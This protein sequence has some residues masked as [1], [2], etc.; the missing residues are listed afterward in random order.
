MDFHTLPRREL[1]TLC[2]WNKIP[3]NM[4]NLAMADALQALPTVEGLEDLIQEP[5][6]SLSPKKAAG[7]PEAPSRSCRRTSTRKQP[8]PPGSSVTRTRRAMAGM[9]GKNE[10]AAEKEDGGEDDVVVSGVGIPNSP[11]TLSSRGRKTRTL[12]TAGSVET[13]E[14]VEAVKKVEPLPL[15][16]SKTPATRA[17][18]GRRAA[19]Q[20]AKQ[21]AEEVA[22]KQEEEGAPAG[23]Q[24]PGP[25]TARRAS[26]RRGGASA[27]QAPEE[28]S[29][30]RST[31]YRTRRAVVKE[32]AETGTAAR[33]R[34]TAASR[35]NCRKAMDDGVLPA[36]VSSAG[37]DG[38]G[39]EAPA[40]EGVV[41]ELIPV[42]VAGGGGAETEQAALSAEPT[43]E[44]SLPI[45]EVD[46]SDGV[47]VD[48]TV[49]KAPTDAP[50]V[51]LVGSEGVHQ[52]AAEETLSDDPTVVDEDD[53]TGGSIDQTMNKPEEPADQTVE[54]EESRDSTVGDAPSDDRGVVEGSGSF[55][56]TAVEELLLHIAEISLDPTVDEE[57]IAIAACSNDQTA[58]A[59]RDLVEHLLKEGMLVEM[60]GRVDPTVQEIQ[61]SIVD[62][63]EGNID[64]TVEGGDEVSAREETFPE[65]TAR[66]IATSEV[67]DP[68]AA[69]VPASVVTGAVAEGGIQVL[70]QETKEEEA[71][72]EE[73]AAPGLVS[74]V[75][76]IIPVEREEQG[77]EEEEESPPMVTPEVGDAV[78]DGVPASLVTDVVAAGGIQLLPQE[79]GEEEAE[80]EENA[81]P[82]LVSVVGEIPVTGEEEQGEEEKKEEE[83]SGLL[84]MNGPL[85]ETE[86]AADLVRRSMGGEAAPFLLGEQDKENTAVKTCLQHQQMAVVKYD[87]TTSLR[88]LKVA[89]KE[90]LEEKKKRAALA[91][92]DDNC[93]I[94][95]P[96]QLF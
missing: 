41:E 57:E 96:S 88:K 6:Q 40:D 71:E 22:K 79:T 73:N 63:Y 91:T 90:A 69:G 48:Q 38:A 5:Q 81:A 60:E 16:I 55:D 43:A 64:L 37:E 18:R 20:V 84:S 68:E 35:K 50:M 78:F 9:A 46:G 28:A 26:T 65:E 59:G 93:C 44:I 66:V 7:M 62:S 92:L 33:T 36:D 39:G 19:N 72:K 30:A 75:G 8:N 95:S 27:A 23:P 51:E 25:T 76:E 58:D 89:Y 54:V 74:A 4:T 42:A 21:E 83:T 32:A 13:E 17:T 24:T 45:P 10:A 61:V 94:T 2:K 3:A 87:N 70:P 52:T 14:E 29:G 49:E 12:V 56:H 82:G 85:A 80:K 11:T 47:L 31:R 77:E 67:G 86:K 1:Q 15:E 34:T 53:P